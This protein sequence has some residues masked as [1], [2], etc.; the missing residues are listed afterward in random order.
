MLAT[1]EPPNATVYPYLAAHWHRARAISFVRGDSGVGVRGPNL[2]CSKALAEVSAFHA[3]INDPAAQARMAL[4]YGARFAAI[5][6]VTLAA[7]MAAA[8]PTAEHQ[9]Q[10]QLPP[11]QQPR[12]DTS[13]A[14]VVVELWEKAVDMVDALGYGEPPNWLNPLRP[15]LAAALLRDG[16]AVDA[17]AVLN[18][19]LRRRPNNGWGYYG[20]SVAL[21][22]TGD[23]AGAAAAKAAYESAWVRAD[24]PLSSMCY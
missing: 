4:W 20:L 12:V 24:E 15:C 13:S 17:V 7:R 16:R 3:I 1:K 21:D 6:N 19:H 11:Q 18:E 5:A 10:R 8:C 23:T 9:Q 14:V 22:A 2:N